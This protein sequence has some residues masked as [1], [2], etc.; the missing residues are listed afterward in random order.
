M[1]V[2]PESD[3]RRF[4]PGVN[5]IPRKQNKLEIPLRGEEQT[6]LSQFTLKVADVEIPITIDLDAIARYALGE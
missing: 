3:R 5:Q 4:N 2:V 6:H 1:R